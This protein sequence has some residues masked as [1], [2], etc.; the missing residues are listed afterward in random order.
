LRVLHRRRRSSS[1]SSLSSSSLSSS[2]L[3][4]LQGTTAAWIL[5]YYD[6]SQNNNI[7]IMYN[8][9][10]QNEDA[11][12]RVFLIA[13]K[14]FLFLSSSDMRDHV[15]SSSRSSPLLR[16]SP[17]IPG[18]ST[19]AD[20]NVASAACVGVA[21][22]LAPFA[23]CAKTQDCFNKGARVLQQGLALEPKAC[24]KK[25]SRVLQEGRQGASRGA[26]GCFKRGWPW[27]RG[28]PRRYRAAFC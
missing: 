16:S 1:S 5:L 2:Q 24:F 17:E 12:A 14:A 18:R 19:K 10:N 27:S 11:N 25:G 23:S 8:H 22:A 21:K 15:G 13:N 6:T 20:S 7:L 26:P 4:C 28:R 9:T 3:T